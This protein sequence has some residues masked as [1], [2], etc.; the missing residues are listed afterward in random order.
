MKA[1][2]YH[3][4]HD[5]RIESVPDPA[6]A[7]ADGLVLEVGRAA[8]CG[9]DSSEWEHGPRLTRPPVVLGHEFV[10]RVADVG[11]EVAGFAVGDR[12]VSG[13]GVSCGHCEWCRTGRT[14]LCADYYTLGLQANGGLAERVATP[15]GICRKVP[16]ACSDTAAVMAQPLAVALHAVR[17]SGVIPGDI[18]VVIGVGGI[19]AF[20]V[21]AAVSRGI[22]PLIAIDIDEVRLETAERLGADAVLNSSGC[23]LD[24]VI[25]SATEGEGAHVVIE[26]SGAP[27]APAAALAG[28]RRGGRALIVGLQA[29]PR[30]LDLF[31]PTVREIAVSTTVAHICDMDLPEALEVLATRDGLAD[32]V[33]DRV[34]ALDDLVE[35]GIRPLAERRAEGKIVVAPHA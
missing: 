1:A 15:A 19:G 6:R 5:I 13:A 32:A 31:A 4:P 12:V 33:L 3:G 14:N 10:G 29:T 16:E 22:S 24:Q 18:C 11:S 28:T 25:L 21:A 34:I 8:I 23:D 20:I 17:R 30:E 2:V 27:I 35:E 7:E 9:T 26:A